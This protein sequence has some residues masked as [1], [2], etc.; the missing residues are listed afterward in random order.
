[1]W[2]IENATASM[3]RCRYKAESKA[4]GNKP[5]SRKGECHKERNRE[6]WKRKEL[7]FTDVNT[8]E[9]TQ[10]QNNNQSKVNNNSG[11]H[12]ILRYSQDSFTK[13][14]IGKKIKLTLDNDTIVEGTLKQVGMFDTLLEVKATQN[15][16]VDGKNLSRDFVKSIIYLKQHIVSIEVL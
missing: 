14:L 2:K 7:C 3:D 11:K 12:K 16:M 6:T 8:M 10:L 4:T 15:I 13:Q 9:T 5:V 1:M